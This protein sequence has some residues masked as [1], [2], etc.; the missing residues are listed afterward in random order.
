MKREWQ[1]KSLDSL[2]DKKREIG[3]I[4]EQIFLL[5]GQRGRIEHEFLE[6]LAALLGCPDA[7]LMYS[8]HICPESPIERCVFEVVL[9]TD[10][11]GCMFCG[12]KINR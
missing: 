12:G 4:N 7:A 3:R 10:D 2:L 5:A 6:E 8:H 9:S 1:G 11:L